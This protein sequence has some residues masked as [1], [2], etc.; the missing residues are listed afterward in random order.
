MCIHACIAHDALQARLMPT[1]RMFHCLRHIHCSDYGPTAAL[2]N[3]S[4][5]ASDKYWITALAHP[6]A[7]PL[8]RQLAMA[9]DRSLD[10]VVRDWYA[11]LGES[12]PP[13]SL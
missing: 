4:R 8:A 6:P 11:A 1:G 13:I 12:R 5:R 10:K 3:A 7:Q 2:V 9:R